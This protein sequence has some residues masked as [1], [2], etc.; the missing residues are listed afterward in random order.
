MFMSCPLPWISKL[1]T[2]ITLS[3]MEAKY[4]ALSHSMRE[5]IEIREVLKEIFAC[6][7]PKDD[8]YPEYMTIHIYGTIPQSK[9]FKDNEACLKFSTLPKISPRIKHIT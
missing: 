3:I 8:P 7:L 9:V 6:V 2:K 5:L 4:I 1:Q